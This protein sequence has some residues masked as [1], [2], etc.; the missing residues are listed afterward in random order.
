MSATYVIA[1]GL[2]GLGKSVAR[3]MASRGARNI[4][5]LSCSGLQSKTALAFVKELEARGVHVEASACDVTNADSL[6]SAIN[7]CMDI[8]PPIKGCIQGTMVLKIVDHHCIR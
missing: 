7:R 4:I 2:G 6:A 1:G 5:L 8:M 3:W